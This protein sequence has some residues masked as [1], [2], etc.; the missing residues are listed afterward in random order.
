M[1]FIM[2]ASESSKVD[3]VGRFAGEREPRHLASEL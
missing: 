2:F 1:P 3:F